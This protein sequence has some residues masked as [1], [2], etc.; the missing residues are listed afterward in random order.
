MDSYKLFEI[1]AP[2][3]IT[4][5]IIVI[6]AYFGYFKKKF[7]TYGDINGKLQ[8]LDKLVTIDT[9]IQNIK[10][11]IDMARQNDILTLERIRAIGKGG[12]EFEY[13]KRAK[14][15]ERLLEFSLRISEITER[16][17][18]RYADMTSKAVDLSS[19]FSDGKPNLEYQNIMNHLGMGEMMKDL[20]SIEQTKMQ[21]GL[22]FNNYTCNKFN[23][24]YETWQKNALKLGQS[25][26]TFMS[27]IMDALSQ[28]RSKEEAKIIYTKVMHERNNLEDN[29]QQELFLSFQH[30]VDSLNGL[31]TLIREEGAIVE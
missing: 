18:S 15:S 30:F 1:A 14:D 16:C 19:V 28:K 22:Y 11:D 10:I 7:E 20:L 23:D 2:S 26:I 6:G 17:F 5:G 13:Q 3:I 25:D 31:T 9:A 27:E 21:F 29:S 8:E 24:S 12:V 4:G